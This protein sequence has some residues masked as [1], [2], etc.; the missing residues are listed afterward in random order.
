VVFKEDKVIDLSAA[1]ALHKERETGLSLDVP[2][3]MVEF[4]ASGEDGAA[5]I[6]ILSEFVERLLD[7]QSPGIESVVFPMDRVTIKAPVPKPGKIVC[8]G[9]N[10]AEHAA[11][12][13]RKPPEKPL[14]FAKAVTSVIG[15]EEPVIYPRNVTQ[16]DYEVEL[17]V[18]IGKRGKDIPESHA[19]EHVGGYMVLNDVTARD[20]QFSDKQW[21]RGK[22]FDTFAPTGPFLVL[23]EQIPDPHAL[24]LQ[25]KI[26]GDVRQDSSTDNMVFKIP[27]LI[28][29]ISATM[30]LEP[31][32]VIATGTPSGVGIFVK[33][34]PVLLN[35]GDVM[36]AWIENIGKLKNT[37]Q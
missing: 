2:A 25:M 32:D 15:P 28:A 23:K 16:L 27:F 13:G 30:T 22:S 35:R 36:E 29:F 37:I 7:E 20:V 18:V 12:G 3:D 26:N 19:Y 6:R 11:E 5:A 21:F 33:P 14:L 9:R 1:C 31:G 8:L 24:K 10:Y 34:E 17:A 4:L